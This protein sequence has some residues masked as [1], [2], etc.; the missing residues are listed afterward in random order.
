MRHMNQMRT[1]TQLM[2]RRSVV[3]T[4]VLMMMMVV[5]VM[6]SLVKEKLQWKEGREDQ[7]QQVHTFDRLSTKVT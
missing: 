7:Q 2:N 4:E 5:M 1:F 3:V 6:S